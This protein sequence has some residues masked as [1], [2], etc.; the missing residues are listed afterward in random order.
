MDAVEFT[1]FI[2]QRMAPQ[3]RQMMK[4]VLERERHNELRLKRL[5]QLS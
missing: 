2:R 1:R 5:Q 3:T 4:D